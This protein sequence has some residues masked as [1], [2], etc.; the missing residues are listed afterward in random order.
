MLLKFD[1]RRNF[2]HARLVGFETCWLLYCDSLWN[3]DCWVC[4]EREAE[5]IEIIKVVF[6]CVLHCQVHADLLC[7]YLVAFLQSSA[8]R[9]F[10]IRP[11]RFT[12]LGQIR[13]QV[14][15]PFCYIHLFRLTNIHQFLAIVTFRKFK[16]V[17]L[18]RKTIVSPNGII[19]PFHGLI[20]RFNFDNK[21]GCSFCR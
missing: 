18:G 13:R 9:K 6:H 8:E 10:N 19:L 12:V 16:R 20:S 1:I 21:A 5:Q 11:F 17:I 3:W 15:N 7:L 14:G 2:K 4:Y